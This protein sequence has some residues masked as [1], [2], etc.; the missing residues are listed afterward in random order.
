MILNYK[1]LTIW[2]IRVGTTDDASGKCLV[3]VGEDL[4]NCSEKEVNQGKMIIFYSV[5]KIHHHFDFTNI[6]TIIYCY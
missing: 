5:I 2:D 3:A 6:F 1:Y 4:K